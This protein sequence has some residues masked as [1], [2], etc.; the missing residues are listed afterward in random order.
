PFLA[1]LLERHLESHDNELVFPALSG[2]PLLTT[3]F[4]TYYWSPVRETMRQAA[5]AKNHA[6]EDSG[7]VAEHGWNAAEQGLKQAARAA[8]R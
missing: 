3:D 1:E 5:A 4:H 8:E 7:L 2:G 6:L